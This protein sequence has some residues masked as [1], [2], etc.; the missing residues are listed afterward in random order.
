MPLFRGNGFGR[1]A[2][3]RPAAVFAAERVALSFVDPL[4][5]SPYGGGRAAFN[6]SPA[7]SLIYPVLAPL[8]EFGPSR[9]L[10]SGSG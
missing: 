7:A 4:A 3:A 6:V 10:S 9:G 1:A 5:G 2:P 8:S